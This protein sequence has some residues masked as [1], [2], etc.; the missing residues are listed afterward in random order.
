M[1]D[2]L[3]NLTRRQFFGGVSS[4]VGLALRWGNSWPRTAKK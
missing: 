1:N 2:F 3:T 4:T